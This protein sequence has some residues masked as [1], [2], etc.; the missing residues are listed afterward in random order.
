M[1]ISKP[2]YAPFI[3][4]MRAIAVLGV[5]LCHLNPTW[6]PGGFAGVDIFFVISGFVVSISVSNFDGIRLQNLII[7]FYGRRLIRIAPA[8]IICLLSTFIT[9]ALFIPDAWLSKDIY[10]TGFFAFFGLSNFVLADNVGSYFSPSSAF[11]PFTQTW[12]LAIEEQFY[13][14]FPLL[15]WAWLNKRKNFSTFCYIILSISS[16][17]C[18][19]ILNK[20][21]TTKS[22]YMIWSRF[23]ELGIGVLLFQL[24]SFGGHSFSLLCS[25]RKIF[26]CGSDLAFL[27]MLAGLILAGPEF[28]PFPPAILSVFGAAGVL[29]F[30]HGRAGGFAYR[31]LTS[32]LFRY[33]G[34]ISYS[35][36]LWHWP[37]LVLCR[38]TVGLDK[39][40]VQ[41]VAVLVIFLLSSFSYYFIEQPPRQA[42][43][44]LAKP[45]IITGCLLLI[46]LS[47]FISKEIFKYRYQISLSTVM[48]NASVWYIN[49]SDN[50]QVTERQE[51]IKI[52]NFLIIS[53]LYKKVSCQ[54]LFVIGDSH[55][56]A[57]LKLFKNF[58]AS[59]GIELYLF[60][61]GGCGFM[62]FQAGID[63]VSSQCNQFNAAAIEYIMD[64]ASPGDIV[65]LP[66]LRLP[67]MIDQWAIFDENAIVNRF[68]T[69]NSNKREEAITTAIPI[70]K[71]LT[72]KGAHVIFE[73]P[74]PML[75]TIPF[76]C[77]DW[78]NKSNPICQHGSEVSEV[79]LQKLRAPIVEAMQ[80]IKSS[81][82]GVTIWDPFPILCPSTPCNAYE[83]KMP[84][85][86]DGDH[87]SGYANELLSK[88]FIKFVLQII[89]G[90]SRYDCTIK[91]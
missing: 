36:Y 63:E 41:F 50:H 38:W 21:D 5:I 81:V 28:L 66:S 88:S 17:I 22:F 70:L 82:P 68:F 80:Q 53:P 35:L 47:F 4:G 75:M 73:G 16:L 25:S 83:N 31:C 33:L 23:W 87:L 48:R 60:S 51:K 40:V 18:C 65:F 19:I 45:I 89:S 6:M 91:K 74:T 59:T 34:K 79:F 32:G 42:G 58:V 39:A 84:L 56:G 8:L 71:K 24:L 86:F 37:I 54:K 77:S 3:D 29:G 27:I 57:Y 1:P 2:L 12:S 15:F 72:G 55:A 76:R 26:S 78:F 49:D 90:T 13:I 10:N 9:T 69:D 62:L 64:T 46:I 11:N 7:Y 14:I 61:Q 20:M 67:R 52:G 43:R 85:F 30:L 44:L